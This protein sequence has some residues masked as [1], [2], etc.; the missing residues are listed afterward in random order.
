M[1]LDTRDSLLELNPDTHSECGMR[2]E[3]YEI[4]MIKLAL[5]PNLVYLGTEPTGIACFKTLSTGI[6]LN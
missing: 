3:I 6:Y 1:W 4:D 2:I 5:L